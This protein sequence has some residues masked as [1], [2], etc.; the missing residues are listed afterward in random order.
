[1]VPSTVI[2]QKIAVDYHSSDEGPA[3]AE[4]HGWKVYQAPRAGIASAANEAFRHVKTELCITTEAD[5][6]LAYDWWPT[7]LKHLRN[8]EVAAAQGIR[9]SVN[10]R[11]RPFMDGDYRQEASR[12]NYRSFD[13]L[14]IR[15][16]VVREVGGVP[17][18]CPYSGDLWLQRAVISAGYK[19]LVD[20]NIISDHWITN[21]TS[22][23][24]HLYNAFKMC[25]CRPTTPSKSLLREFVY[26]PYF[27]IKFARKY[28]SNEL[29]LGYPLMCF[30]ALR[31]RLENTIKEGK[32]FAMG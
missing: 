8:P 31:G 25:S 16:R 12:S 30:G 7:I 9:I 2:G 18:V 24:R 26:S 22:A 13:N 20:P 23:S 19:W 3:I 1:M 21:C 17:S 4:S 5:C 11:L 10:P 28:Q 15:T 32:F 27:G 29:V 6:R 14:I